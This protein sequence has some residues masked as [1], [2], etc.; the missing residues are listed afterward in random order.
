M[1]VFRYIARVPGNTLQSMKGTAKLVQDLFSCRTV[2]LLAARVT[3]GKL[4]R[5][6]R[7]GQRAIW[8]DGY[9]VEI[10]R[11]PDE[12]MNILADVLNDEYRQK[13]MKKSEAL[14]KLFN[15]LRSKDKPDDVT[16]YAAATAMY[17]GLKGGVLSKKLVDQLLIPCIERK[18]E[19]IDARS[20][21]QTLDALTK[22][23]EYEK[24]PLVGKLLEA[25]KKRDFGTPIL[26]SSER[27]NPAVFREIKP[28]PQGESGKKPENLTKFI[29][30]KVQTA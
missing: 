13:L 11:K 1:K 16:V 18:L 7:P 26:V 30:E 4:L 25:K 15:L 12:S 2:N 10:P 29:K 19:Y 5:P 22:T 3:P 24:H 27:W 6:L 20:I 14:S 17:H 28:R 8:V 9:R 21:V 23:Q